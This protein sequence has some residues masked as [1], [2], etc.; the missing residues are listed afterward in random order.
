[1]QEKQVSIGSFKR[2]IEEP[3]TALIKT[4]AE[5]EE[6]PLPQEIIH[7]QMPS[8]AVLVQCDNINNDNFHSNA[9]QISLIRNEY[10]VAPL[11]PKILADLTN[12]TFSTSGIVAVS[13]GQ[14]QDTGTKAGQKILSLPD[15]PDTSSKA[16]LN[17]DELNYCYLT[18]YQMPKPS[19]NVM[20]VAADGSS[21]A[22]FESQFKS[23]L[24]QQPY[25]GF[26]P[27][28]F[29]FLMQ[30][31]HPRDWC[32]RLITWPYPLCIL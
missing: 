26:Y 31:Q 1:M 30:T 7:H 22:M 13:A 4:H 8:S 11:S 9:N 29:R 23:E 6:L 15:L 3:L 21:I 18:T 19:K 10:L 14:T 24:L 2:I 28:V 20:G 5:A 17:T 25:P 27:Q 16:A 32:L 12:H